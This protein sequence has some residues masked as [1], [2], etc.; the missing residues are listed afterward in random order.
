[1]NEKYNLA[2][3]ISQ[4]NHKT[5]IEELEIEIQEVQSKISK[6]SKK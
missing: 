3:K 1:M 5:D 6:L 4:L 2:E